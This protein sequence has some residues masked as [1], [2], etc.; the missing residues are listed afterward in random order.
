M[1]VVG[2]QQQL[3]KNTAPSRHPFVN[4]NKNKYVEGRVVKKYLKKIRFTIGT[5]E[6]IGFLPKKKKRKN[7]ELLKI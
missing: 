7:F 2:V 3:K 4:I 6:K 5:K 1:S